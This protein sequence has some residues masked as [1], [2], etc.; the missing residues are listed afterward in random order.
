M[1]EGIIRESIGKKGTK[2][3][4]RDGYL[5]ANIYGKGLENIH[6]AF[7]ENEY[8][9]TVRNKDTL[10]FPI[11]IGAKEM[12]VVVQSYEAHPLTSKLL[13]VD[14]MVAQ[15]GVLT[16][17]HVPVVPEGDA[18]GLKNKGLVHISKPRLRVKAAIENVPNSIVVDVSKMDVGDAK[19]VRDIAKI[20]N[21][22]F[23]DADRVSVLSVI[24]AK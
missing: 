2:A 12:N 4:R 3:L 14:L 10:A 11:K 17:Y 1:L 21:V 16:H 18:V 6:A 13:H 7:K 20:E 22:T 19:M 9:R 8:I 5:I 24:K 23:T 15:T